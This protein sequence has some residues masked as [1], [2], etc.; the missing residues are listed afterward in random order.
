MCISDMES[1]EGV[2]NIMKESNIEP[3]SETYTLLASGYAKM[4]DIKKIVEIIELCNN[5]EINL[6]DKEYLDIIYALT[7]SGY[8]DKTE[9]VNIL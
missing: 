4:G 8:G 5:K 3:S 2:L 7:I 6:S 1:A 9:Q